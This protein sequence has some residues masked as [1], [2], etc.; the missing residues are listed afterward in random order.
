MQSPRGWRPSPSAERSGT[1]LRLPGAGFQ[2]RRFGRPFLLSC[3][4]HCTAKV[5]GASCRACLPALALSPLSS[6]RPHGR[7]PTIPP[8][9]S[10][11]RRS[12][13]RQRLLRAEGIVPPGNRKTR[14]ESAPTAAATIIASG[15]IRGRNHAEPLFLTSNCDVH[16]SAPRGVV[17]DD[18]F[19]TGNIER[20]ANEMAKLLRVVI[21]GLLVVWA[22]SRAGPSTAAVD[23]YMSFTDLHGE[24]PDDG[25]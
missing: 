25:K 8:A 13:T 20:E 5:G 18:P 14:P 2:I 7:T 19:W 4:R 1:P 24:P 16:H 15:A 9:S 3:S 17:L 6:P 12:T 11:A 10:N 21:V 22:V 23:T